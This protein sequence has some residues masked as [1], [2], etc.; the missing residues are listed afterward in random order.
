MHE[1]YPLIGVFFVAALATLAAVGV[2]FVFA[3]WALTKLFRRG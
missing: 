1:F 3:V 2:G